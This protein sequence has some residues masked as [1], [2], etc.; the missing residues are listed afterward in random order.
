MSK[1]GSMPNMQLNPISMP[2]VSED[3]NLTE[4]KRAILQRMARR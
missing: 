4:V 1:P 3:N 2:R